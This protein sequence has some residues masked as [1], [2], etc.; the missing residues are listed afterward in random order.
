MSDS[1][2][3]LL[4]C[5]FVIALDM[6]F[7]LVGRKSMVGS[8]DPGEFGEHGSLCFKLPE[9]LSILWNAINFHDPLNARKLINAHLPN[10]PM[11]GNQQLKIG[12]KRL[13][14]INK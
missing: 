6:V 4:R 11:T 2:A 8:G 9:I 3:F 1:N 5:K 14:R 7:G 13:Y 10:M 12:S